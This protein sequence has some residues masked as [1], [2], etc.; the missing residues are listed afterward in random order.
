MNASSASTRTIGSAP[1]LNSTSSAVILPSKTIRSPPGGPS[2][3]RSALPKSRI[4]PS[5]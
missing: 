3:A 1:S 4:A 2:E 5:T